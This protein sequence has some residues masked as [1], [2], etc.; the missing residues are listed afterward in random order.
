MHRPYRTH[1]RAN[2]SPTHSKRPNRPAQTKEN[3]N[4]EARLRPTEPLRRPETDKPIMRFRQTPQRRGTGPCSKTGKPR[5]P[6][7]RQNLRPRLPPG[8]HGREPHPLHPGRGGGHHRS[9]R[10]HR[11]RSFRLGLPHP[12]RAHTGD[13]PRPQ[14]LGGHGVGLQPADPVLLPGNPRLWDP[15]SERGLLR[16]QRRPFGHWSPGQPG[17][18]GLSLSRRSRPPFLQKRR[19]GSNAPGASRF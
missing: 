8:R 19:P 14:M 11:H 7:L 9:P 17:G 2:P 6:K 10:L 1:Y 3:H 4:Q 15:G 12:G 5:E 16:R 18:A 13:Q